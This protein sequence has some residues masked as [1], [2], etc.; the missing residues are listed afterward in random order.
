[1]I[2]NI[3]RVGNVVWEIPLGYRKDMRVPVRIYATEKLLKEMDEMVFQQALNVSTL[4]GI[5]KYSYVMPDGHSGYGF[6]IGGVAAMD[7][8]TGVISPGGIGFDINCLHPD[9]KIL[10]KYGYFRKIKDFENKLNGTLVTFNLKEKK[11]E[12]SKPILLLKKYADKIL[13]IKTK[14]GYEIK[15]SG[16]HPILTPR[17]MVEAKYLKQGDSIAVFPFEG[18]EYVEPSDEIILDVD[19]I[20][21]VCNSKKVIRE[22]KKRGLLPLRM[23][24]WQ[25]PILA[26][27]VGYVTGDGCISSTKRYG[28]IENWVTVILGNREDLEEIKQDIITLGFKPW[29]ISSSKTKSIILDPIGKLRKIQGVTTRLDI[30]SKSFAILLHALGVP[31]GR[32]T[33]AKFRVPKWIWKSPKWIK[34]LYLAGLFGAE[35]TKPTQDRREQFRFK[36]PRLSINKREDLLKNGYDFLRDIAILLEEFNVKVNKF[37]VYQG[38]IRKDKTRTVKIILSIS[39]KDEN[40]LNLWKKIGYEYCRRKQILAQRAVGYLSVKSEMIKQANEIKKLSTNGGYI[41]VKSS[42]NLLLL[43]LSKLKSKTYQ[44]L[45]DFNEYQKIYCDSE[46]IWDEI[47]SIREESYNGY[48][49]DFT[50]DH[51]DHNF[52]ANNIILS[53]CGMRLVLTNLTYNE[54]R[55]KLK[56]L[57]DLLFQRVPAG[58]GSTGFLKLT[59]GE[60]KELLE[61]GAKWCVEKGYGWPEDLERTEENGCIQGADVSKISPKAIQRGIDQVG[62]LGSGNHYLEI[63]WVKPENIVDHEA[64]KKLGIFENQIVIMFHCGSRGFGHQVATDY[65]QIFLSVMERKYGIKILDRELACAPFNSKEGQDYFAAMKCGI[66]MSFANRQVILHRIREVFSKVFNAD[67]EKLGLHMVYDVAHNTAKLEEYIIDGKR[68][69]VLVHRKGATRAFGPNTEGIPSIYKS[70]GQP[71]II[72]G[73]METGSYLLLGTQKAMEETFGTTCHGSGRT[74]SRTKA[75]QLVRGEQL[76]K[77]LERRGIYVRS[78]SYSGVAEE[79][80]IAYKNIDEVI[81]AVALAGISHKVVRFIPIGNI[82]G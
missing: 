39:S 71:V 47:K 58:V 32:K 59:T 60:F 49:Y 81:E 57:V 65:L 26:K 73:S 14:G 29:K 35:L 37:Y 62:T 10:D 22:L 40:L 27:L 42:H 4:P 51:D 46:I 80:G 6:P 75:K 3:K 36:E 5:L 9:T 78:V 15:V 82:K 21:K 44:S 19:D 24:S 67:P 38:A 61:M 18:V 68:T 28:N 34:R 11:K 54:V 33:E 72:G 43:S 8:E 55:P 56:E 25:T 48:L 23:N 2:P 16:D 69:K 64:A 1:M 12:Y 52:V 70:L 30:P 76:I 41:S 74:M 63:Q 53:N 31:K 7:A 77:D 13:V 20:K 50:V 45:I 79:A 66:N 17:G